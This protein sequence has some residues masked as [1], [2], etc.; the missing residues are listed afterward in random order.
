[1]YMSM[2]PLRACD[3]SPSP[4]DAALEQRLR[5]EMPQ[6][7]LPDMPAFGNLTRL[8]FMWWNSPDYNNDL[9]RRVCVCAR[10]WLAA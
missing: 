5:E 3:T 1:M 8:Q 9:L 2:P 6:H 10:V 7:V 4:T